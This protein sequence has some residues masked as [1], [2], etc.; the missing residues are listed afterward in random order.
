MKISSSVWWV[1]LAA[2]CGLAGCQSAGNQAA[3][4]NSGEVQPPIVINETRAGVSYTPAQIRHA[5]GFDA[6]AGTGAGQTIAIVDA[7]GS[8]TIQSDLNTFDTK[9]GL[10]KATVTIAYP[11]G[12]PMM[13]NSG[14]ASETALDVEWAHAIAPGAS[15]LLVAAKSAAVNDLLVAV[16]YA[17]ARANQVSMSWGAKEATS[18]ATLESHFT[19][20]G[21]SFVA[22][23]GDSA[24][25]VEWPAC[26]PNVVGVGG[27]SLKLDASNNRTSEIAWSG[28]G[29]GQSKVFSEPSFQTVWQSS[30][31]RQAPDVSYVA[32]PQT[33]VQFYT[34][35]ASGFS[36]GWLVSGGTSVGA[37]QWA[38]LLALVN[39]GRGARL[40][41]ANSALYALGKP[42]TQ[43]TY[44]VDI[45]AGSNGHP[46]IVGYD[47]ATGLGSPR[48]NVLAPALIALP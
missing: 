47:L 22:A 17:A 29:G 37:P 34:S 9:F 3:S 13:G 4:L 23:S 31:Y 5:Y 8:S 38:A 20:P 32:D 46:A 30:G 18:Y 36:R 39:A 11:G 44:F 43:T 35:T 45:T 2:L 10:P 26:S 28:G 16:D 27:T 6:F 15:L 42:A 14:W 1:G 25:A 40:A 12:K 41:S 33:G 24:S 21:V 48:A 19:R 7:Y